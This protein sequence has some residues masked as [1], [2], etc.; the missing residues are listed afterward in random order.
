MTILLSCEKA[1]SLPEDQTKRI[2]QSFHFAILVIFARQ[3]EQLRRN[4]HYDALVFLCG[5]EMLGA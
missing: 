2:A 1:S 4:C 3:Q 5:T